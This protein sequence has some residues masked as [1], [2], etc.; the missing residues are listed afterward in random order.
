[1]SIECKVYPKGREKMLNKI[2]TIVCIYVC[3]IFLY[4]N[5]YIRI[6]FVCSKANILLSLSLSISFTIRLQMI[7]HSIDVYYCNTFQIH[8]S[9]SLW[10]EEESLLRYRITSC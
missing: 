1:M 9:F 10:Y 6:E 8:L 5:K 4:I 2:H 7:Y 3:I